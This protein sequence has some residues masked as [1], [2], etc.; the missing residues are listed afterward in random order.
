MG[1]YLGHIEKCV[2]HILLQH[3]KSSEPVFFHT[4]MGIGANIL[5]GPHFSV[6][7]NYP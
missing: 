4:V 7:G 2:T 5:A 6:S 3:E 1:V